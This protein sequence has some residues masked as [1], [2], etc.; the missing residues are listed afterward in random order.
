MTAS[1]L[2][3]RRLHSIEICVHDVEPWLDYLTKGFGFQHVAVNTGSEVEKT[4]TSRLLLRCADVCLVLQ[5]AVHAGS[6][7]K[8][9]L[10]RHPE[11]I[12]T[13]NFLVRD[14][15]ATERQLIE[16]HATPTDFIE[17]ASAGPVEWSRLRI[18]TPLG[19]V[20]FCFIECSEDASL[21]LPGME[22]CGDFRPD[23]NP[24]GI[25]GIDHLTANTR[26]LMPVIAFYEHVLGFG[27]FW[28]VHFHPEGIRP[29]TGGGLKSVVMWDEESGIKIANSEPLRPRFDQSQ[30]QLYVDTNRGPGIH[31][32]A[33]HVADI[34]HAV[35]QAQ[36]AGVSFLSTPC[37][38]YTRLPDRLRS[39]NTGKLEHALEDL[40]KREILLD[41]DADGYL[42]QVFCK[43]QA[44]QFDRPDA[45]PLSIE[46]IQR[47]GC[48]GFGAGNFRALF[49]AEERERQ[50]T[51]N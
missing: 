20:E 21:L 12:S 16:R 18:A 9:Y 28:D 37:A 50:Q 19:D 1:N 46:I 36:A 35:D 43:D 45:G 31:Q 8:R 30:V 47:C 51:D 25:T 7:V 14:L 41:A 2:G 34:L 11:G 22:A 4:G 38:Y 44:V 17:T 39:L 29:G 23:D 32:V 26:T 15:Q 3:I 27:R 33:F 40:E 10:E 5:E 24:L 48:R 42:L 49:E 13:L 6:S